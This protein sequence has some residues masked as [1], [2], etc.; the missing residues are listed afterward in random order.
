VP[1]TYNLN[2]PEHFTRVI[3]EDPRF[4]DVVKWNFELDTLSPA[5]DIGDITI[6]T[7]YP[8]DLNGVNRLADGKPDLGAF[9]RVE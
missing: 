6:A 5:K 2:D 3:R 9:E 7:G 8:V 1:S 4:K